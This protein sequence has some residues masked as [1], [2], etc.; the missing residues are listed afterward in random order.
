[1]AKKRPEAKGG[2]R[3][4]LGPTGCELGAPR[5]VPGRNGDTLT[6]HPPGSNGGTK[7]GPDLKPRNLFRAVILKATTDEGLLALPPDSD[8]S[9]RRR[10]GSA[11]R[12][13]ERVKHALIHNLT[14]TI[15]GMVLAAAEGD[16]DARA[17]TLRFMRD[18][19]EILQP[20][21]DEAVPPTTTEPSEDLPAVTDADGNPYVDGG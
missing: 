14:T 8:R 7:R 5:Q 18:A 4:D 9:G 17:Q 15:Q 21:P 6:P 16:I 19:H 3:D 1:M 10:S 20:A 2:P 12:K 13:R 11:R